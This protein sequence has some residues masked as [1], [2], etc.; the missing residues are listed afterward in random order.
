ME[1]E[2]RG[3]NGGGERKELEGIEKCIE[4]WRLIW[5]L[6]NLIE[7]MQVKSAFNDSGS[8]SWITDTVDKSNLNF[9]H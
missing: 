8:C 7:A 3:N 9:K 1:G 4:R 6:Y 5:W 2:E